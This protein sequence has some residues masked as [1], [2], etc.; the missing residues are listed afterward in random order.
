MKCPVCFSTTWENLFPSKDRLYYF[1]GL[2]HTICCN[3][4]GIWS[5]DPFLDEREVRKYYPKTYYSYQ[6]NT[7][8]GIFWRLRSYMIKTSISM[9]LVHRCL[10]SIIKIPAIPSYVEYGK[11]LDIGCGSGDTLFQLKNIGWDVYGLDIDKS[12]IQVARKR[13]L[14]KVTFGSY[15]TMGLYQDNYFDVIR[16]YHVIEHLDNPDAL[17]VLAYQKLKKGGELIIGTPNAK[18]FAAKIFKQYWYNLDCPRHLYVFNPKQLISLLKRT[19]FTNIKISFFSA[20]G[21]LGSIQYFL[22]DTL[23]INIDLINRPML[24][25]LLYPL[26]RILDIFGMGDVFVISAKKSI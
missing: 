20:G 22:H 18:S 26:E 14:K 17:L 6:K 21:I 10:R 16:L 19:G 11:I 7:K 15:K 8:P 9:K 5:L 4:C 13:G 12:A 23:R 2:F 24:L 3:R 1:P 25:F